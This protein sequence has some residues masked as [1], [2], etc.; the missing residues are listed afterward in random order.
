MSSCACVFEGRIGGCNMV[1]IKLTLET[2]LYKIFN[3]HY[4]DIMHLL[5]HMP[6]TCTDTDIFK[7][8]LYR[9]L[10]T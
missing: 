2:F 5:V 8:L 1:L 9:N 3:K 10:Y 6:Q 7:H 4:Y